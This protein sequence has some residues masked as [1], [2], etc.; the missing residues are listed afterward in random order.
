MANHPW[1]FNFPSKMRLQDLTPRDLYELIIQG[2]AQGNIE[3]NAASRVRG[4][5]V[6]SADA[7]RAAITAGR[8]DVLNG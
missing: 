3:S 1:P 4:G 2:V 6:N 7:V 8:A 5:N